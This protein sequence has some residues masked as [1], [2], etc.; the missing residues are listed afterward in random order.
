M[1]DASTSVSRLEAVVEL[2][3]AIRDRR[4]EDML[5]LVDP[6]V[7]CNPLARPGISTY[8]GPGGMIQFASDLHAA[9]GDFELDMGEIAEVDDSKITVTFTIFSASG[10]TSGP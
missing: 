2:Y 4:I 3:S 1:D 5:G 9:H 6:D 10:Q 7:T 8:H